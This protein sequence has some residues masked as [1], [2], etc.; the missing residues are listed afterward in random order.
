M[1]IT[2]VSLYVRNQKEALQWFADNL[3]F[4]KATDMPMSETAR[5]VTMRLPD[6]PELEVVLEDESM[7]NGAE[8][9]AD[10]RSRVG[11]SSTF[12]FEVS[13]VRQLVS[14]LKQKGVTIGMEPTDLPWGIQ[15]MIID[16]YGNKFVLSQAPEGGYPTGE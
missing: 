2:H 13:D 9:A 12:V 1:K 15:A 11:K 7:A 4:V 6:Q 14:D 5:W 8:M 16:P 10:L 3:G